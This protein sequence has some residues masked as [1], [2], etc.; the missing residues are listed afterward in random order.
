VSEV[1]TE[2]GIYLML[3]LQDKTIVYLGLKE[4]TKDE[5]YK[6]ANEV[7]KG[8]GDLVLDVFDIG[9][10]EDA[11]YNIEAWLILNDCSVDEAK[12]L[13]TKAVEALQA[14]LAEAKQ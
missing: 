12:A 13:T 3:G 14:A 10:P 2:Q 1:T 5:A 9:N 6:I 7:A 11:R 4:T 8:E